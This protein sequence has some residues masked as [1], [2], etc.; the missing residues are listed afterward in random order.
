MRGEAHGGDLRAARA[1]WERRQWRGMLR[2]GPFKWHELSLGRALRVALGVAVPLVVGVVTHHLDDGAFA[3][4]GALPAGFASFEGRARTRVAAVVAASTGM[5][6]STFVGGVLAGSAPWLLVPVVALWGYATGLSVCLGLWLSVAI[7]QW[8]VALLIAVGIPQSPSQAALRAGLVLAG[9][10][11]QGVLVAASWTV[12]RGA[13]ERAAL[14]ESYRS[15][16]AYA[17]GLAAGSTEPPP[18]ADFS[19]TAVVADPNPL[20]SDTTRAICLNLLEQAERIRASLAALGAHTA[21]DP[22]GTVRTFAVRTSEVLDVAAEAMSARSAVPATRLRELNAV[23]AGQAA[24]ARTSGWHWVAEALLG[25]LRAVDTIVG[26]MRTTGSGTGHAGPDEV[27]QRPVP[28]PGVEWTALTLK[29]NLTPAGETGRHAV[30][31]AVVAG[32]AELMVHISGLFQGRWVVLTIFLVLKPDFASTLSR[33]VHRA[34][35]TAAGAGLGAGVALLA[36]PQDAGLIV[37]ATVAV[38]AAY[39][40]FSV[41]YLLFS[42]SLTVFIVIILDILGLSA[43]STATAR[44]A[45]TAIG[46]A[47]AIIAYWA[48]PTWEGLTAQQKFA[49]LLT[50]QSAYLT[51]LLSR[52]GRPGTT[53]LARLRALQS[54][55]RRARTDADAST[56]RLAAEPIHPP[57]T[58]AVARTLV[59]VVMRLAHAEL[60]LHLLVLQ[61]A[62]SRRAAGTGAADRDEE[63][64]GCA[65]SAQLDA[66]AAAL[67]GTLDKLAEALVTLKAPGGLPPLRRLEASLRDRSL[68]DGSRFLPITDSIVDATNTLSDVLRREFA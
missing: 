44:L 25:Q 11:F 47:L 59:A 32:L 8:A 46:A 36:R 3:A 23:L 28:G 10:L 12:Q 31:L 7:L 61:Q 20:L 15:L 13:A 41:N 9:G 49:R 17:S 50:S 4:L 63:W 14:A 6:V 53:D 62:A 52:L 22:S 26:R 37:G 5:A 64:R 16:S 65:P 40:L 19:A 27:P 60:S 21:A 54:A 45:N 68:P 42:V 29:A 30:R 35:G 58:P 24:A 55:A 39:A 1:R 48:W 56:A 33:S 66:L 67:G 43:E 2:L 18:P 51:Y 57:L 38:A 34:L